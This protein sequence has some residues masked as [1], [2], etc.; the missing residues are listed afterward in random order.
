MFICFS[1]YINSEIDEETLNI[2]QKETPSQ[3]EQ[4]EAK[5][6][7]PKVFRKNKCLKQMS[8]TL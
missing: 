6:F 8:Y 3:D 7:K 5:G 1:F 2:K 4:S